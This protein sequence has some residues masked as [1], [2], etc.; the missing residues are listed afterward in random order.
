[1]ISGTMGAHFQVKT[2]DLLCSPD[3]FMLIM[4]HFN[5]KKNILPPK[6]VL[7]STEKIKNLPTPVERNKS[8]EEFCEYHIGL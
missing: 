1:M 5:L 6:V 8:R 2:L 3:N 7:H 4:Y